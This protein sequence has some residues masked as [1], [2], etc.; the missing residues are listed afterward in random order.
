MYCPRVCCGAH[1]RYGNW[2]FIW[3]STKAFLS[4]TFEFQHC[5]T[6]ASRHWSLYDKKSGEIDHLSIKHPRYQ[7]QAWTLAK[8]STWKYHQ[9]YWIEFSRFFTIIHYSTAIRCTCIIPPCVHYQLF[10]QVYRL[11]LFYS[12]RSMETRRVLKSTC[13]LRRPVMTIIVVGF[14][15]QQMRLKLTNICDTQT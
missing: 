13:V 12:N 15:A 6:N 10:L 4:P 5:N 3:T 1:C 9:F 7:C 2:D 8:F 11:L 14:Y